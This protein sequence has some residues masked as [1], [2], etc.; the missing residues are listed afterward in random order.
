VE[1]TLPGQTL[2][3]S[4]SQSFAGDGEQQATVDP[5][6][7]NHDGAA[8]ALPMVAA[9]LGARQAKMLAQGIEQGGPG[10]D[11]GG[12]RLAVDCQLDFDAGQ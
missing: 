7:V 12:H 5:A 2:D 8:A 1:S 11:S 3:R 4:Y 10:I 6:P 9:L